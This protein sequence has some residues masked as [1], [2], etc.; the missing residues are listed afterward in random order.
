[1]SRTSTVLCP[2]C[3]GISLNV[4]VTF[5]LRRSKTRFAILRNV[6]A[7]VCQDCGESEYTLGTTAKILS[8]LSADRPPDEVTLTPVYDLA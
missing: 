6:P 5:L 4:P 8:L 7:D 1:M 3:G 2:R